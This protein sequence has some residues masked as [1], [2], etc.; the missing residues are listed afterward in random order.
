MRDRVVL[1]HISPPYWPPYLTPPVTLQAST[2]PSCSPPYF[3]P[4]WPL[5]LTP[6]VTLQARVWLSRSPIFL[7]IFLPHISPSYWPPYLTPHVTLQAS[8]WPS[9]SDLSDVP[10]TWCRRWN[11]FAPEGRSARWRSTRVTSNGSSRVTPTSA[12]HSGSRIAAWKVSFYICIYYI[13]PWTAFAGNLARGTSDLRWQG[14]HSLAR[15][16]LA[17]NLQGVPYR[18]FAGNGTLAGKRYCRAGHEYSRWQGVLLLAEGIYHRRWSSVGGSL[19]EVSSR[20]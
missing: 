15:S 5:Y 13:V 14:V 17:G 11:Y 4:Y 18:T 16:T 8:A 6:H 3:T 1:P 7:P 10:W 19:V 2:W 12:T 20:W 9:R